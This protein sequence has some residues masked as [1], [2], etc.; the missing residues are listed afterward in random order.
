MLETITSYLLNAAEYHG[1][2]TIKP[3]FALFKENS[4]FFRIK[5]NCQEFAGFK[6]KTRKL[7][8]VKQR[9]HCKK[10]GKMVRNMFGKSFLL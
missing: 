4:K 1:E 9:K 5:R 2:F 7:I 10:F 6:I 8:E 3:L